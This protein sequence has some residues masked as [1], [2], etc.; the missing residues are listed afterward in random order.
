M[1]LSFKK[2]GVIMEN[3]KI[4]KKFS[5]TINFAS[6]S[7]N[8]ERIDR[9]LLQYDD[10]RIIECM[11]IIHL[12]DEKPIDITIELSNMYNCVVG[13]RFCASGS[14]PEQPFFLKGEDYLKQVETCLQASNENPEDYPNFYIA[15][16][17]IGEP[18]LV[19]EEIANGIDLIKEKYSNVRVV[20]ATTG[21]DNTCFKYWDSRNLPIRTCNFLIMLV[22]MI[23]LNIL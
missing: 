6:R 19:K 20:I 11:T 18:S 17:G 3:F 22:I 13:C 5:R 16:T 12:K 14:L 9:Y 2:R 4:A 23:N 10:K 15:F 21:F 1:K 8:G 7:W